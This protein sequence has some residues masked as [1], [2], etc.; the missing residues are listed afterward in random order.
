MSKRWP[1]KT[2][3]GLTGN[4]AT[5]KSVV[6]RML[7]HLGAFTIDADGL[8][9][10]AMSPG[11]PAY[12]PVV[13]LFGKWI[14][15]PQGQIDRARLGQI[16]FSSPEAMA[17]LEKITH[18]IINQ[19]LDLL[20]R[21]A[22]QPAVIIEAIKLVEAGLATDCDVVWVVDAPVDLQIKRLM[23]DRKMTRTEAELR[24]ASQKTQTEQLAHATQIIN[25]AGGYEDTYYQV[26]TAYNRLMHIEV[27]PVT[28]FP[29]PAPKGKT[30]IAEAPITIHRG[31]PQHADIIASFINQMQKTSLSRSD[32][33]VRFG[34]KAYML[35][36][37]GDQVVALA[38]W[39]I[40]N[41]IGRIDEFM[42]LPGA[43][44]NKVVI[45]LVST[46]EEAANDLQSEIMLL[47][48]KRTTPETVGKAVLAAGYEPKTPA[49]LRVPDWREAAEES[50]PPQS[51]MVF[52]RLR[53]DRVLKPI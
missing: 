10:R 38:G 45:P 1:D 24:I 41:L 26:Q 29:V 22:K 51:Y 46:I 19:V 53:E 27:P 6:R 16:A 23:T 31:T 21:R 50:A 47:Y 52:K 32:V 18:P 11:A 12:Q 42:L 40:E 43:P 4:I 2:V 13:E 3:I 36:F 34:Q 44:A 37:A 33:M 8:V 35:A 28:P 14:V 25:N 17:A 48:L 39:Q 7:E 49:D 5:G 15:N 9:H 20:I 30:S